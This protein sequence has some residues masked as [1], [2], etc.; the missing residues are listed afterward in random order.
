MLT[1]LIAEN[2]YIDA[3]L[4]QNY[5]FFEPFLKAKDLS[6]CEWN[7]EGQSF[8]E[9]VPDLAD[10][11]ARAK[12]WR[13]VIIA[14]D[15]NMRAE[16][17]YDVVDTDALLS[18]VRPPEEPADNKETQSDIEAA[19]SNYYEQYRTVKDR[20]YDQAL[21]FPLQKLTTMLCYRRKDYVLNNVEYVQDADEWAI[22]E[23]EGPNGKLSNN[24][25][26]LEKQ[27]YKHEQVY[28]ENIRR[29]FFNRFL[30]S[31]ESIGITQPTE[32]ICVTSRCSSSD[33]FDPAKNWDV[34]NVHAY[35]GFA[36]R[37]MY[38]DKMFFMVMDILPKNHASYRI[39]QIRYLYNIM[40]IASNPLPDS[41]MQARKLYL[42]DSENDEEPLFDLITSYDR[43]LEKTGRFLERDI[44][45]I[46]SGIPSELT[47]NEAEDLFCAEV[48]IPVSIAKE[49][50]DSSLTVNRNEYGLSADCPENE[51]EK[52]SAQYSSS[53][54]ALDR[55]LKQPRRAV[56]KAVDTLPINN[57]IK[58]ELVNSLNDFQMDDVREFT[59]KEEETMDSIDSFDLYDPSKYHQKLSRCN[60]KIRGIMD[61][62]MRRK[63]TITIG[64]IVLGLFL[65]SFSPLIINNRSNVKTV[66]TALIIM[67]VSTALIAVILF[68]ALLIMRKPLRKALSEYNDSM[69]EISSDIRGSV[70]RYS[71]YLSALCNAKRGYSVLEYSKKREDKYTRSIRVRKKHQEDLR[72]KRAEL[73]DGYA[74][75]ISEELPVNEEMTEPYNYDFDRQVDFDYPLEYPAATARQIEFL[76][77]G[78]FATSPTE[79]V[80]KITI[81]TE[82]IYD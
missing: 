53:V 65:L 3:I 70:D 67:G 13:A 73:A 41:A 9:A 74:Y 78:N 28:K 80:K 46:L 76:K 82:E 60:D 75:F 18:I 8:L 50:N 52:W 6:V 1:V 79:F 12:E 81:Q 34:H 54:E 64:L 24:I 11:V 2:K 35:S 42:L 72:K 33:F 29:D 15:T 62:R 68:V 63:T 30:N 57:E 45:R 58:Y 77:R 23:L 71:K 38:F 40:M 17:P 61:Q 32:V 47:D 5:F 19:W 44:D 48:K 31:E 25:S 55:M 66:A 10:R 43:K 37:N 51:L 36:D 14:P 69:R 22:A 39:D 56:S 59:R 27:Q 20:L 21:E 26:L 49:Q 4:K 16:N 7:I